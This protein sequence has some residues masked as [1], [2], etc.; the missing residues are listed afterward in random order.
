[1][2]PS[3]TIF[4]TPSPRPVDRIWLSRLGSSVQAAHPLASIPPESGSHH[5]SSA[6]ALW[7]LAWPTVA[8]YAAFSLRTLTDTWM[9]GRLG[10]EAL[11]GL[12]PAQQILFLI[13]GFAFGLFSALNTCVSHAMGGKDGHRH[14]GPFAWQCLW[15]AVVLGGAAASLSPLAAPLFSPLGH[16]FA[17]FTQEVAY[18]EAVV[19][20]LLP[21]FVAV[22][23]SNFFFAVERPLLPM[24]TGM[25]HVVANIGFNWALMFGIPGWFV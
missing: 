17:I 10:T 12:M 16:E 15:V 19:W 20:A 1:M 5:P 22:S 11:A 25:V 8:T 7:N 21:Q 3:P 18:F 9:V 24:W 13:Q 2:A 4:S 23:L 6:R 14:A